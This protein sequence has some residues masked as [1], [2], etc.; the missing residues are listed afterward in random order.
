MSMFDVPKDMNDTITLSDA[1]F[2]QAKEIDPT[3]KTKQE[4]AAF[5]GS[6][7]DQELLTRPE[8][9]VF[10]IWVMRRISEGDRGKDYYE[11]LG[12]IAEDQDAVDAIIPALSQWFQKKYAD[13]PDAYL[14]IEKIGRAPFWHRMSFDTED[15]SLGVYH[16]ENVK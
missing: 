11:Q 7:M 2:E 4:A 1:A 10:E 14:E 5:L 16:T 9:A 8:N 6:V 12:E 3:I 15:I 13:K